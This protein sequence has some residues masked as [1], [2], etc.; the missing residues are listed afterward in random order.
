[1]TCFHYET[2]EQKQCNKGVVLLEPPNFNAGLSHSIFQKPNLHL[3]HKT[4]T[5]PL[6]DAH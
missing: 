3:S 1:M 2:E 4:K 6:K 5:R